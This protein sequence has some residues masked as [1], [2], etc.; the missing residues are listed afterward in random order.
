MEKQLLQA[1]LKSINSLLDN[2]AKQIELTR[3]QIASILPI[4]SYRKCQEFIEKVKEL[5]LRK[6]SDRQVRKFN[7]LHNKKEGNITWQSSPCTGRQVTPVA[8]ASPH[9]EGRQATL[10]ARAPTQATINS[11]GGRQLHLTTRATGRQATPATGASPQAALN[12]QAGSQ[13]T[14][15]VLP[16]AVGRQVSLGDSTLS[17]AE[18]AVS[19]EGN[20]KAFLAG[21]FPP[22]HAENVVSQ[23]G[24][25][26]SPVD[27]TLSKA[28]SKVS[29]AG[30]SQVTLAVRHSV[31]LRALHAF[32]NSISQTGSSQAANTPWQT[33]LSF[34]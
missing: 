17:Q 33:V 4:S 5:R 31:S 10:A 28:E 22:P 29:Q 26:A 13:T 34:S 23:T 32:Q 18:S 15:S 6:V 2:I 24:N 12:T 25:Q 11:Q 21:S 27:S 19:Q 14:P 30:N 20:H 3:S 7:N 1:R 8:G 9:V 16:H